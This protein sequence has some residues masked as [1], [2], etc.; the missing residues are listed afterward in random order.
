MNKIILG[1]VQLGLDYG[2]NNT[3]GK[4]TIDKAIDILRIAKENNIQILDTALGYGN[5]EQVI[6][7][8]HKLYPNK[9]FDIISKIGNTSLNICEEIEKSL[10]RLDIEQFYGYMF[11]NYET[12]KGNLNAYNELKN[13]KKQKLTSRIGI[14]LYANQDIEDVINNHN[15]DFIQVPFN[16]LDNDFQKG[17]LLQKAKSKNIEVHIR[18]AFLQG[19]FFMNIDKIPE[20][21]ESLKC[22][23]NEIKN[24]DIPIQQLSLQYPL[25]KSYI[26]YV[27][28]GVDSKEQLLSNIGLQNKKISEDLIKKIDK[29]QVVNKEMLNPS[30]W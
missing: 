30:N 18:S 11:H 14:S 5:S 4:P 26:D 10:K 9:K 19:L 24:L 12:L 13:A 15:F 22:H 16:L 25:S 2:I 1:T 7:E 21:V 17:E 8:Y 29:I 23:L 27:V 6:G 20:K 3:Q 28:I